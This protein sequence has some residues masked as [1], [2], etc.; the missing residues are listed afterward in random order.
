MG[1][2][3]ARVRLVLMV[4]RGASA[5]SAGAA[6]GVSAST[7]RS[8]WGRHARGVTLTSGRRGGLKY[9]IEDWDAAVGRALMLRDRIEIQA[10][11]REGLSQRSIAGRI[12][13]S[14]SVVSRELAR[15]RGEDGS[16]LAILAHAR[17]HESRRRPKP[18]KLDG[19]PGLAARIEAW[20]DD[21]WSPKLIADMLARS[22]ETERVSH[23][24]IYR[25][26]YVQGRGALRQDLAR[27][28]STGRMSRRP[29]G[30]VTPAQSRFKDAFTI[31]QRP[32]EAADRAVPGHWEG[33][34]IM[35]AD[36]LSAIGTLVERTTRYTILLHLPGRHTADEVADAMIREMS[37]LPT[38]LRRSI[39]WDRGSEMVSYPRIQLEL[40]ARV[41]FCDPRSPWQRGTNENTNR[42]LRH[43]FTKGT[44][45]SVHTA[46]D[47]ERVAAILNNRPRPTLD[48]RTPATALNE[49]LK[50]A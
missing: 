34:L 28:L 22:G 48:Y 18:L 44:D 49:L 40:D 36:N 26:L 21:G 1:S 45:L 41:F 50:A 9:P 13:R 11:L 32:A 46:E 6:L 20:M 29:R 5:G 31:S 38:H 4:C 30:S 24:T 12:G 16:Y 42:L 27:K 39:T 37:R 35:G 17:A 14:Q 8:W 7:A 23:E 47:L 43:W 33:D 25:A 15:H 2:L 10:G 3:E 19:M